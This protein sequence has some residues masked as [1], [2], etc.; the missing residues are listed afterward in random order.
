MS[1]DFNIKHFLMVLT[2]ATSGTFFITTSAIGLL[3]CHGA[4]AQTLPV[5][6]QVV[7]GSATISAPHSDSLQIQQSSPK[8]IINW[9]GFSVGKGG[10]VNFN[11]GKGS[12]LNRVTGP[13]ISSIDGK[14]SASGSVYLLNPNGV[15][16]GKSGK[17]N[18]GGNFVASTGQLSNDDFLKGQSLHIQNTSNEPVV[19]LGQIGSLGGDVA[20]IGANVDNQGTITAPKGD[21]GLI[22]GHSVV[23]RDRT[24]DDGRYGIA[25]GGSDTSVS[26]SGKID[27]AM[28]EL[29]AEGGNVYALAGNTKGLIR[30]TG[31]KNEGGKIF[32]TAGD[33]G[34]IKVAGST[35]QATDGAGNGGKIAVSAKNI[36]VAADSLLSA[37]ANS[38]K[39]HGGSVDVI[40]NMQSGKLDAHGKLAA[41]GGTKGGNGGQVETSG[42]WVNFNDVN[43][44]TSAPHGATGQW[45]VDPYD[46]TVDAAAASTI[47]T[48]LSNTNVTLQTTASGTSGPGIANANGNGDIFVNSALGWTSGNTLTLDA[49]RNININA[50]ISAG[51]NGKVVL[52]TG[53]T[54]G[55]GISGSA[56]GSYSFG[57]SPTGFAGNLTFG[58]TPGTASLSIAT[59]G[60]N[61]SPVS[62][63]LIYGMSGTTGLSSLNGKSG[64]YALANSITNA[65]AVS[66][67][68]ASTFG[69]S[70]SVHSGI[71]TGLGNTI[72]GLAITAGANN[73]GLF[74]T[75]YGTVRDL[76]IIN[77][78]LTN[79]AAARNYL[80]LLAGN[81]S[82]A[83]IL[84]DY[85]GGSSSV[86]GYLYTGGMVGQA[87]NNSTINNS[88]ST[89]SV[90]T[91]SSYAGGLVGYLY[92]S[93][94]TAATANT[95]TNSW[96]SGNVTA[97]AGNYIGG[98]VGDM[99]GAGNTVSGSYATGS[100]TGPTAN[101]I[102]GLI[103]FVTN[104]RSGTPS[105]VN[106]SYATGSVSGNSSVGGLIGNAGSFATISNTYATG[107]VKGLVSV[108]GLIGAASG[109]GTL[110]VG[111]DHSYATGNITASGNNGNSM[112]GL[113]GSVFNTAINVS[114]ATGNVTGDIY[115]K[116]VGGLVGV[117]AS[118]AADSI[119]DAYATGNVAGNQSVGGA[120]GNAASGLTTITNL[121]STGTVTPLG[122]NNSLIGASIGTAN[123]GTYTNIYWDSTNGGTSGF[124]LVSNLTTLKDNGVTIATTGNPTITTGGETTSQLKTPT[125]P[126]GF[127]SGNATTDP[128]NSPWIGGQGL[129]PHFAFSPAPADAQTISGTGYTTTGA[130]AG[131]GRVNLYYNGILI[132][133]NI[134]TDAVSGFYSTYVGAGTI[135]SGTGLGGT[136]ALNGASNF[137]GASYTD[138]PTF[139]GNNVTSFDI[140]S[141]LFLQTTSTNTSSALNS[142]L[143]ATFG[144]ALP[145][146]NSTLLPGMLQINAANAFTVNT[147]LNQTGG[148]G[149]NAGGDLAINAGLTTSGNIVLQSGGNISEGSG[150]ALSA[151]TLAILGAGNVALNG[152]S[153]DVASLAATNTGNFS[154]LDSN[155]LTIGTSGPLTTGIA[156]GSTGSI[157]GTGT[158]TLSGVASTGGGTLS[159]ATAAGDL[160]VAQNV[161]TSNSGVNA[162]TLNAGQS[163]AA[164]TASGGNLVISGNPAISTGT[165]GTAQLYSGSATADTSLATL[166]G[167]GSGHFRY[168][169]DETT[170]NYTTALGSGLYAIYRQVI[171]TAIAVGSQVTAYGTSPVFSSINN[172]VNGD[173]IH[174]L[175]NNA[176]FSSSGHYNVGSYS[177]S[178]SAADLTALAGLGYTVSGNSNGTLTVNPLALTATASPTSKVYDGTT[179]MNGLSLGASGVLSGDVVSLSGSGVYSQKNV[180]NNIGYTVSNLLLGG[181]D[182]GNYTL[183]QGNSFSGNNGQITQAALTISAAD[184]VKTYD[185]TTAVTGGQAV[186]TGGQL[187]GTDNLS[188]GLF[189]YTNA[190]AGIGNKTVTVGGV[191]VNDGNSGGNYAVT[192]VNNT[193]STINKAALTVST[194]D[195]VKT[196][197]GTTSANGAT[198]TV[199]GGQLFGSDSLSGGQFAY[200]NANAGIGNKTVTVGGVTVNDGNSGGNYTV[201]YADN[202]TSTINKAA[203][204]VSTVDVV[205]TYDSTTSASGASARVTSGQL[206]GT[207]SL[208]GGQF[209]YTNA[210]AGTGNKTVTVGGVTV[211]DGNSGGN[212]AVTYANNTTSTI[213]KAALT[214]SAPDVVKMYDGTTVVT[215][216]Q[217]VITSGQLF[218]TDSLSGGQF[219]YT[220]AN[221]G[222]G[223]KTVTVGGVTLNDGNSGG[224]YAVT[225][226]NNTTSTINPAAVTVSILDLVKTYDGTTSASGATATVTSGQLFGSD[227][228]NGGLFAYTNANAGMNNKTVTVGGVT[229]NDGNSGGNYIVSYANNTTSTINKAALTVSTADVV[230]TYDATTS[231]SGATA[232]VT[233]G[234]LFGS[235]SLSGGQFAYSNAN[236]GTGNKTVTVGGVTVNDGNSGGNYAVTYANNT[237]STINKAALTLSTPDVVKTYDGTTNATAAQG[238]QALITGGQLFG[239]DSLSGGQFAY[240]NANAGSG[241]KTVTVSGVTVNDGNS[242]GNYAVTYASNTSST[243]NKAAL[244]VTANSDGKLVTM[245]DAAG[246]QGVSYTGFVAGQSAANLTGT[247]T[248]TR[249]GEGTQEMAGSYTGVLVPT[250]LSSNNYTI[251]YVNGD[252]TIV[253][254]S[255][256]LIKVNNNSPLLYG[257]TPVYT[258]SDLTVSYLGADGQTVKTLAGSSAGG[259]TFTYNDGVG[260]V[261]TFTLNPTNAVYSSGNYLNVGNYALS[262]A[263]INQTGSNFSG[264][265]VFS[266]NL[267]V[268]PLGIAANASTVSKVYDG[269]TAI[270]GVSLGLP[271]VLSGDAV[272]VS[273]TGAFSQKNVGD[274]LSYT[275]SDLLLSGID[276]ANYF[277]TQGGS[278]TGNNG[279]ITPASLIISAANAVKTYDGTIATSG[280]Q[281]VVT[282]GQLFGTDNLSGGLF[283]YTNANAGIGNKTVTV[284]GVTVNDDNNGD[285]YTVSY[286]D[287]TTSTINKAAL[288]VSTQDVVK[289]YDGTTSTNGATATVTSGQLFGT[290]SLSGGQ[291]AYTNA[292]AGTGNK[293]VTVGGVT[294]NDGN[295]GGNYDVTYAD[296][297]TSTISK[298]ALTVSTSDVVKTYDGTTSA[299]GASATV[300]SGQLFGSDSLSGGQF[301]YTN[302]NAGIGDKT[303][304]V[305]GVTVNDGNNGGNYAVTYA[306][307]ITSTINPAA[308]TVSTPDVVKTYDGTTVVI[309]GQAVVTGGQLYGSDSLSGGQFAYTN[310]NAGIGDKTVTVGGVTVNDGNSGG[311]YA[312]TYADNTTS[313]IN[314][315]ALT[316]STPDVVKTY[317]GTASASGAQAIITSGQL[318]GTDNLSGGQFAYTNA[319]AGI[320][321]KTV[322]VGGVTVNDG[323]NGGN[324]AVTYAN[325]TTSTI[326]PAALTVSTPDVVKTYDGTTSASGAS[327]TVTSGQL[328][329]TDSLSG[330]LFA[331]TDANAGIGNKTVT[332]G[333]VT[334][335]DG[336][337]GGNYTVSYVDNTT[338]TI[339]KA[340]L[341]ISILDLVKTYDGTTSASGASATVTSGQLFGSDRLSGGQFAYTNANAGIGNKTVTV[342]GVTVNDDNSGGNY[343]VTYADNTTS[344]INP[345]TLTVSTPDVVKNYD[346]TTSAN[347]AQAIITSGQ[348]FGTDSLSGGQFAYTN[349]NAGVGNKAVTVSG[350]TVNDGNNG[351]NYAVTYANNTSSTI[352]KAALTLSTSD[353]VK[354]YDGTTSA[355]GAQAIITSGQLFGTDS[356]SGGQ[357]A[358]TNAN[359]GNGN[360]TVTVG[361]VTLNDGN[362]G[363]NYAVTYVNNTTSTINPA[364]VTISILDL[365][366][367]YDGT[368]GA[369]GVTATV[370]S[371]QLFGSDNLSGGQFDYTDANA[372]SGNKTVTVGGVMVN[373]GNNGGNY[374]VTYANNTTST[375]NKANL[376]VTAN[377]DSKYVTASDKTGY[378]GVSYGGFVANESVGVLSGALVINRTGK[379]VQEAPG[380]YNG[381]LV[382]SGLSSSNY[383]ISYVNGNYTITPAGSVVIKV[384]PPASGVEYGT[385][386]MF[387]PADMTVEYL[388][389]NGNVISSLTG[390]NDGNNRFTF[391]DG[392]GGSLSF[393]LGLGDTSFSTGDHLNV[394]S[395]GLSGLDVTTTGGS[396]SGTPAVDGTLTVT[397]KGLELDTSA[398]SKVYDGTTILDPSKLGLQGILSHD[399]V[400]LSGSGSLSQKNVGNNLLY[401]LNNL[402]LAGVDA[403]NYYLIPGSTISGHNGSITPA[404]LVLS[405]ADVIKTYDGNILAPGAQAV[406]VNGKLYGTDSLSGGLFHYTSSGVGIGNKVVTV[407]NVT[408]NDGNGGNNYL[409][410]YVNNTTSTINKANLTVT[411]DDNGQYVL[412]GLIPGDDAHV[413]N[414]R[415]VLLLEG[416][417]S[418]N[419]LLLDRT[420]D[421]SGNGYSGGNG[422]SLDYSTITGGTQEKA[423]LPR[424]NAEIAAKAMGPNKVPLTTSKLKL[425]ANEASRWPYPA[426]SMVAPDIYFI[427]R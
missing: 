399:L 189:A 278:F 291:F 159:I 409:V 51:N 281:A 55:T 106:N 204:T 87:T 406:I 83:T 8:A 102:G 348:L 16:I 70:A 402:K 47:N 219:A 411:K 4:F 3:Y 113:I 220:N 196:Y 19:N 225:Y 366:K 420:G 57:L 98:L 5:G 184:A 210:N 226:A 172:L 137:S 319:N 197:D 285:N 342:G 73:S 233:S 131:S 244:T 286:V 100:V 283:A 327:A 317:D 314:K 316:L 128:N 174:Y 211:N 23:I 335:N 59:G 306:N 290:D 326:N 273:G 166:I 88:F 115:T 423:T 334:V 133:S 354:A 162:I 400:S 257:T 29:R 82:G 421:N 284:G 144:S 320:G 277:L 61:V 15:I 203:L 311:N 241:D 369:S 379:G 41:R 25:I 139:T 375:I 250:G 200:T 395:Y 127:N 199:T 228:L 206:F 390:T 114:F 297:T 1:A 309:G 254:A 305:G 383:A 358:Y 119:T 42:A 53:D 417:S 361:G 193:S 179:A 408:V 410:S 269:T 164:G 63:G 79:N 81:A 111:V 398:V 218:G 325:N 97:S 276:A 60:G 130:A 318:F 230:K 202:T 357:F 71:F 368:T 287:N 344:T 103:G 260:G 109:G 280:G 9:Q 64:P 125:L 393:T 215:G 416:I 101:N 165:G 323:N 94:T 427:G 387:N 183:S 394:G 161:T 294:V 232:T 85:V 296:N 132:A 255:E 48:N 425:D 385:T 270:N 221:A 223:N 229:V 157:N 347:G 21:V 123:A 188:G 272:T 72:S 32:L 365:V 191:T 275:I 208:S 426:N 355:N 300:A 247:A 44:D 307:N 2:G 117:M 235:D 149:L 185:G 424:T 414:D 243:I 329:G 24:L 69:G 268:N 359:A 201:S 138:T 50:A 11:N 91:S 346:G 167:N 340:A 93:G 384:S 116:G 181:A 333:G 373:D 12:T 238:A 77:S 6:G 303:V 392:A 134:P 351:G 89:A 367:T 56:T 173:S 118:N 310:A 292:N 245:A 46:L 251:S 155:A 350:V 267:T 163:A 413:L 330:G 160:T 299:S 190:N 345:A 66:T 302:A 404:S 362:S 126:A 266:G 279:Q 90:N 78:T 262:G 312:V 176:L 401:I 75:L 154:Y 391:T 331:Y 58:T 265:P 415:G 304:T 37:S 237:T 259:N 222:N 356:L 112:G 171:N 249:T 120:I 246:Y 10:Q 121:M 195:V 198:A 322:T 207:D 170:Q 152:I 263:S 141:G 18:V 353:V 264:G 338:S 92:N 156:A 104:G 192:Y 301:A 122:T 396:F 371:G 147:A 110:S 419:Y 30:A 140:K 343:D 339:N 289:S 212:Y 374:V 397:P 214:L 49:Y 332:V 248:V 377:N 213:N 158:T 80:G 43:V 258:T 129:Y 236:A 308:L 108:G 150:G 298:A 145:S 74:G 169:S 40:A 271:G 403:G 28:V 352:N 124:G 227:S 418:G 36:T 34:N 231:A 177:V 252:Y 336:N 380:T 187:F 180:G 151:A 216:G 54:A 388:D 194:Q 45:L 205:K 95:I 422:E 168:N 22:A 282:G 96:S 363:G 99:D 382:A 76:G 86:A 38:A 27:A 67:S 52:I 407:R 26:N 14:L 256:L 136:L 105:V 17:V 217:A 341:T 209:A 337:N 240:T 146:I 178:T 68:V 253:P 182:A 13:G 372:G 288:T 84:N 389:D 295:S 376:I 186:V 224:N 412:T 135:T 324:Y 234:Q 142:A 293:T 405:T 65:G 360:K 364:A 242:G 274:N 349:A 239:T 313:T 175:V 31:V 381:V 143:T 328:F 35:L 107:A 148:I 7:A 321:N 39:G 62:Y 261:V 378:N 386:P 370:T 33:S 153:N 315:A 20:L